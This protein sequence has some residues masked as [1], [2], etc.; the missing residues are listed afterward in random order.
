MMSG[1]GLSMLFIP[2]SIAILNGLPPP[3]I[4]KASSFQSLS[5]QLG[6]SISTATLVTLLDRR[7]AFHQD[8]LAQYVAPAYAPFA[9]L[10][11]HH[12]PLGA[13]YAAVAREASVMSFADCQF[14]LGIL[15]L[16]LMPLVFFMPKRRN[17]P[18]GPVT[19]A[20]E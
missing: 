8:V 10:M 13:V 1:V 16:A 19:I 6:G 4:P 5:L 9:R 2:I 11:T 20:L 12:A 7:S 3:L 18:A 15:A 17:V 14:A